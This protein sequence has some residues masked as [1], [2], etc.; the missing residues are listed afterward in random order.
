MPESVSLP[1]VYRFFASNGKLLYVGSTKAFRK[2]MTD[3][4][5]G[6]V[7]AELRPFYA[8][9]TLHET[10]KGK[11]RGPRPWWQQGQLVTV[12][13][14]ETVQAARE[15]ERQAIASERPYYNISWPHEEGGW[16][17][18]RP[19]PVKP[20]KGGFHLLGY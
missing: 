8:P 13:E 12:E 6:T 3:H 10:P 9:D 7:V 18:V 2:R 4:R 16:R 11:L 17:K 1:C 15:R 14:C 20:G 5:N 19:Q